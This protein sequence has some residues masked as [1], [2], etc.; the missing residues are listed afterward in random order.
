MNCAEFWNEMPELAAGGGL[1][2]EHEHEHLKQ[3]P[4]CAGLIEQQRRLASGLRIMA[5]DWR[6]V[7][8]PPRVEA[9]LIEAFRNQMTP[10]GPRLARMRMLPV[11]SLAAVAA[12]VLAVAVWV[13]PRRPVAPPAAHHAPAAQVELAS[14]ADDGSDDDGFIPLPNAERVGP[15]DDVHVVRMELPRS[16][17]LVVGLDV[18]PERVSERVEAEVMLGPDGLARAVRFADEPGTY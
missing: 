15:N 5:H 1:Q 10:A 12:A 9:N 16:A 4:Q 18:S 2:N 6:A 8:A 3:C 13:A 17:M 7:A 14:L 11:F